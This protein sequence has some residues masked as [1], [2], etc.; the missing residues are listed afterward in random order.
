[1]TYAG[2][3]VA[4]GTVMFF[5]THGPVAASPIAAD[6]GY[7]LTTV[8]GTHRVAVIASPDPPEHAD[9]HTYVSPPPLVPSRYGR[10][11]TSQVVVNVPAR[12]DTMPVVIDIRLAR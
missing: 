4:H 2:H 11:E 6:G 5:P 1:V 8:A 10:P 12:D 9:P 7:R 3:V